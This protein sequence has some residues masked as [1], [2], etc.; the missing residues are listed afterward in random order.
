M[1]DAID[2]P[3]AWLSVNDS[4]PAQTVV[5]VWREAQHPH[6]ITIYTHAY[7][8]LGFESVTIQGDVV[9]IKCKQGEK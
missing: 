7:C 8:K 1:S 3:Q 9:T 2:T 5:E 4:N 6:S